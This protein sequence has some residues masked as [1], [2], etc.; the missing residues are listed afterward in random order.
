[1]FGPD[2]NDNVTKG[3]IPRTAQEIFDKI[4]KEGQDLTYIISVSMLEIY[5]EQLSDLM[6]SEKTDLKIKETVINNNIFF[7]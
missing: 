3:I 2:I 4:S 1:M 5:R 6:D 7:L